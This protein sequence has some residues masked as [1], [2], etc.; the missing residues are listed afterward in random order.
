[1]RSVQRLVPSRIRRS[2]LA[3]F[4]FGLLAVVLLV[5]S[6]GAYTNVAVSSELSHDVG[7]DAS[8]SAALQANVVEEWLSERTLAT[9][10]L[11]G[12]T[13]VEFGSTLE[14]TEYLVAEQKR[15]PSDVLAIHRVDMADG[16]VF[17]SSNRALIGNTYNFD[18]LTWRGTTLSAAT[19]DEVALSDPHTMGERTAIAFASPIGNTGEA[20]L[21]MVDVTTVVEKLKTGYANNHV[22]VVDTSGKIF[23]A[24]DGELAGTAYPDGD[25]SPAYEAARIQG[26]GALE[27]ATVPG[28][29]DE[30]ALV[31]YAPIAGTRFSLVTQVPQES[32]YQLLDT[33]QTDL[34][35]LL[36]ATL[37]GLLVMGVVIG[38][39][40]ARDLDDLANTARAVAAGDLDVSVSETARADEVGRVQNA[41]YDTVAY[42]NAVADQ[43]DALARQDFDDPAFDE[44]VPGGLGDR[45]DA[46]SA[47]LQSLLDEMQD[48]RADSEAARQEA[49]ALT[50]AL[51]TKAEAF[52]DVLTDA[53]DGDL[54]QRVDPDSESDAMTRIAIALNETLDDL[55]R[56]VAET[57][58]FARDVADAST[59]VTS[60]ASEIADASDQVSSSIT[61]IS[62]TVER[63]RDSLGEVA[64]EMSSLSATIEEI[65]ASADEVAG[66]SRHASARGGEAGENAEVALEQMNAID[67]TATETVA[68]VE[69]L[70][71]ELRRIGDILDLIRD[72]ADQT[73]LLALNANIEAARAGQAGDGFAVVADE[74]KSLAEETA[75]AT[76]EIEEL[77]DGV[78]DSAAATVDGMHE[79]RERVDRGHETV[80][81][82]LTALDDVVA[83]VDEAD[84]GVQSISVATDEQATSTE[85]TVAMVDEVTTLSEETAAEAADVA[86]AAQQQA[87]S[88]TQVTTRASDLAS[89]ADD[90]RDLL[91]RFEAS[92]DVTAATAAASVDTPAQVDET[93]ESF[94]WTAG[95]DGTP[96]DGGE[97]MERPQTDTP[98]SSDPVDDVDDVDAAT[99]GGDNPPSFDD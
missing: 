53:A 63:Q 82:A 50:A 32:A 77:V 44:P 85:E 84:E 76:G 26:A 45:L 31:G 3:K 87:A 59:E 91:D 22:Q 69:A 14:V 25:G 34:L 95:E 47:D 46:M 17:A 74:I 29:L 58:N 94:E 5:A 7:A 19:T 72:V 20:I 10:M 79:M 6:V 40:T 9:R 52:A 1:M 89:Q 11:S 56:T 78:Q 81:G 12:S 18:M 60:G 98:P 75:E 97:T 93:D 88:V 48:A 64:G 39:S 62:G 43:A 41:F 42:I 2:Y 30:P 23:L 21:L 90:L 28:I 80:S 54:T 15:L 99:D 61:E 65:A 57:Q 8:N 35:A 49:E 36:G 33:I 86:A 16:H 70:D 4:G 13:N 96:V 51:E 71:D 37:F 83:A 73:N 68:D 55:E 38:R 92:L 27:R 66:T 24:S 67:Q